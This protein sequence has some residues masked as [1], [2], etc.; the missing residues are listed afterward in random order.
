MIT[1]LYFLS[2][3][4]LAIVFVWPA[5]QTRDVHK[6]VEPDMKTTRIE[7]TGVCDK[8]SDPIT[9]DILL[10]V[11][12]CSAVGNVQQRQTIRETWAR[13]QVDMD[14]VKVVFMLGNS[15]NDTK[16]Q[17]VINESEQYGD[18]VQESFLDTYANLTVK[19]L[20]LLKW[21][22]TSCK[23]IVISQTMW[24]LIEITLYFF[25]LSIDVIMLCLILDVSYVMKTDDDMYINIQQLYELVARNV[26]PH[27][28]TG[29][30]IC[31]ARPIRD[32]H[33]KWHSPHY[34]F[35]GHVYPDYVS[36][37]GYLMSYSTAM[38]L[39]K[40]SLT[41]PAFHLEDVYI[42]GI[43]PS[44]LSEL[45]AKESQNK[46]SSRKSSS[47]S[48]SD[49]KDLVVVKPKDDYRFSFFPAKDD[50]CVYHKIISSHHISMKQIRTMYAKVLKV[51]LKPKECP[52]LKPKQLRPYSPG[53]CMS[54]LKL[55][56]LKKLQSQLSM[57]KPK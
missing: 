35:Q 50:P 16:Q 51:R 8:K 25:M 19:S 36:G 52:I 53:R 1:F 34:M 13:D 39:F 46:S 12:V 15:L 2:F 21:F 11:V 22:T 9:D 14:D 18:I 6:L 17:D 7:P 32:P 54:T 20:M 43:L 31:G 49:P 48:P 37:T 41:V 45:A 30:L 56:Q 4:I 33:N 5:N 47:L 44:K 55:K 28:L 29:A 27:L 26:V 23:G 3:N 10:L 57:K 38:I 24:D 40:M 42:T